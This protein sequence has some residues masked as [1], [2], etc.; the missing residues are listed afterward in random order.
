MNSTAATATTA[1]AQSAPLNA[2]QPRLQGKDVG[3]PVRKMGL[4]YD[5]SMPTLWFNNNAFLTML[6]SGFSATL[7]AGEN[8]FMHSVRLFQDQITDP[9]LM[10]QV[11]AFI[12][13]EAHHSKEH[14][15][16]NQAMKARGVDLGRIEKRML[17][18]TK[19]WKAKLSPKQQLA[20]TVCA[21]HFTALLADFTLS[22]HPEV[23]DMIAPEV[24]KIWAWHSIEE[25][26]HKAV[27]FDVY[28]QLIGD[29]ALL[30]S[31][32][33]PV[34]ILFMATSL[35]NALSL[36]PRAE[37][38]NWKMWKESLAMVRMLTTAT[39]TEYKDFY[40]ADFHPWMHDN[41]KAVELAKHTY[42]EEAL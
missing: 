25:T 17:S 15:T 23:L 38:T 1:I 2:V 34:T 31:T 12:G 39:W 21:E 7:P 26:E 30:R 5:N 10:A 29:R 35:N 37:M 8:H 33:V 19:M 36:M 24:R 11:R 27:A 42:L 41:R 4:S 18:M 28:Q 14:D 32:M 16:L 20:M 9:V 40:N 6:F 13:Q 3:I 22:K